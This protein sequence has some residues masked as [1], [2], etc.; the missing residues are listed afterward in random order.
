MSPNYCQ[1][2]SIRF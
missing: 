1:F 2:D